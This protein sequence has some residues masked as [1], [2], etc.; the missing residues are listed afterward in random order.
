MV[1]NDKGVVEREK[2]VR[3]MK[4]ENGMERW[5]VRIIRTYFFLE[6]CHGL[7]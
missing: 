6:N 3:G 1:L 7:L 4:N 5:F 2:E